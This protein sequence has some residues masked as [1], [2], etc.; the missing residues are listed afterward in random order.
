MALG[1]STVVIVD[2]NWLCGRK[3]RVTLNGQCSGWKG[4]LNGVLQGPVLKPLLFV[5]YVNDSD[6]LVACKILK[7]AD[8]AKIY[9]DCGKKYTL[10][11][12]RRFLSN[13]LKL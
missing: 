2:E 5:M 11:V 10:K 3:Q 8:D 4:V 13:C 1:V 9:T 7:F 6:E 12:F